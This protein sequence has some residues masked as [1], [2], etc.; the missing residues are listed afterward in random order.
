MC[1]FLHAYTQAQSRIYKECVSKNT[2]KPLYPVH[3]CTHPKLPPTHACTPGTRGYTHPCIQ[4][5]SFTRLYV[6]HW[7][8]VVI[9]SGSSLKM[10]VCRRNVLRLF[11]RWGLPTLAPISTRSFVGSARLFITTISYC[12]CC[13]IKITIIR[14]R[15]FFNSVFVPVFSST[16]INNIP[17]TI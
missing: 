5:S 10:C 6:S 8:H 1:T 2:K 4:F 7:C 15:H 17:I 14:S 12:G 11:R 9:V 13:N 16:E 3:T